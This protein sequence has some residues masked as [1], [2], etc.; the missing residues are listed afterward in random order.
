[1][2]GI[3][4]HY[5][6]AHPLR[7]RDW[8][9]EVAEPVFRDAGEYWHR[10]FRAKHFTEAGAQEYGYYQRKGEGLPRGSKAW[11]RNYTGRKFARFGHTRP[12]VYTG[13]GERLSRMRDVRATSKR[14]RV[15]LPRKFNLKHPKS[16]IRMR[17]ELTRISPR[18]EQLII[19]R[20]DRQVQQRLARIKTTESKKLA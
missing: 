9:T 11:R 3:E 13:E 6:G 7:R 10:Q 19:A 1:M 15:V 5:R 2:L 20:A 8:N 12:L 14:V 17:D 16:R 4:V 18:E